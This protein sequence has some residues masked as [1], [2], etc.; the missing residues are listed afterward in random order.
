[1]PGKS[2]SR[3]YGRAKIKCQKYRDAKTRL[4]NK[5]RKIKRHLKKHLRDNWAGKTLRELEL[6]MTK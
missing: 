3:K 6:L 4:K 5:I 1:M 2:G